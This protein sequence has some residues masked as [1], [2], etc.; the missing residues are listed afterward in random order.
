MSGNQAPIA[1]TS[2]SVAENDHLFVAVSLIYHPEVPTTQTIIGSGWVEIATNTTIAYGVYPVKQTIYHKVAT[3]ADLT[4]SVEVAVDGYKL[5]YEVTA[6]SVR[7]PM[8]NATV[9]VTPRLSPELTDWPTN[10]TPGINLYL[11]Q[12]PF[13]EAGAWSHVR[14]T[15][16]IASHP[17]AFTSA[18][19][20]PIA[21]WG[22]ADAATVIG[23]PVARGRE[24]GVAQ[25]VYTINISN[26]AAPVTLKPL[27]LTSNTIEVGLAPATPFSTVNDLTP[28]S[29]RTIET[30][31]STN[32]DLLI[33]AEL[34][35]SPA[36][37][38]HDNWTAIPA[39]WAGNTVTIRITEELDG[40][41]LS[42]TFVLTVVIVPIKF[43][44]SATGTTSLT[45]PEHAAGDLL[46]AFS[47]RDGSNTLP[48]ALPAPWT[49]VRSGS[50]SS[51]SFRLAAL[52]ATSS[53]TVLG[54][55]ATS[56]TS[57]I[58]LVYRPGQGLILST[59]GSGSIV[60]SGTSV[61]YPSASFTNTNGTSWAVGF[62]G[63]RSV[64]TSLE[65]P[66]TGMVNRASSVDATDEVAAHDT[67]G[68]VTSWQARSV[69]VNG[70][71]SG[72]HS[73]VLEI[74]ADAAPEVGSS[75]TSFTV[76]II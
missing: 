8:A 10:T 39:A 34:Y 20:T 4:G 56:A 45:M 64:N 43:I 14:P 70:T 72:W 42:T 58:V 7:G 51:T 44:S 25:Y 69:S 74:K 15:G 24:S 26:A 17:I 36:V 18:S 29:T 32:P 65:T 19:S 27:T 28:G 53:S 23:A 1:L 33:S 9:T 55:T 62:A 12:L 21:Q 3:A 47:F 41:T 60:G 76:T 46:L 54:G 49:E 52:V 38:L 73:V 37:L 11:A 63:H 66:P 59:G 22:Y 35:A 48:T 13:V 40:S 57:L 68:G 71:A 61:T 30:I 16:V 67:N 6:I 31:A 75:K 5:S 2:L 50:G